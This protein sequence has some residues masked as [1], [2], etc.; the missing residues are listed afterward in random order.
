MCLQLLPHPNIH[1]PHSRSFR[2]TLPRIGVI[3]SM[4]T[5][6]LRLPTAW[7]FGDGTSQP[8]FVGREAQEEEHERAG[9]HRADQQQ[10]VQPLAQR[11][12]RLAGAHCA[13]RR[14]RVERREELVP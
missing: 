9:A 4:G 10:G 8:A 11:R 6:R 12:V 3:S 7:R 14:C 1:S 5:E 2:F 13:V